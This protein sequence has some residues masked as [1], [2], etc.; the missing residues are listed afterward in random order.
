DRRPQSCPWCRY[1]VRVASDP[2]V[3]KILQRLRETDQVAAQRVE[4]AL[5]ELLDGGGLA[6]LTQHNLQTYLWFTLPDT[7]EP[8]RTAAALARF[9][10]LAELNRY[11]SIAG[12]IQTRD[13]LRTYVERGENAGAKAGTKAMD[14]SGILPPDLPE[15]EWGELMGEA[16]LN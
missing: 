9:F 15:L 6:D 16:E 2:L 13:I 4:R 8:A 5:D 11:A 14:A 12:S 1:R 7:D 3:P 10:E